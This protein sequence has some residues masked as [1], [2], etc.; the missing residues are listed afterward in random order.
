MIESI[1]SRNNPEKKSIISQQGDYTYKQLLQH[2][3]Q[4][5]LLFDTKGYSK[6][7]IYSENRIEWF[8]A[9]YAALQNKCIA[10]PIDFM[11][12]A[13]DVAYIIDDC[14]PD[15]IFLSDGMTESY[16]KVKQKS[17]HR[18]EEIIFENH[19]PVKDHEISGWTGPEDNDTTAVI[20]YTSGTTGSPKGVMLSYTNLLANMRA[21]VDARIFHAE[22]QVLVLLPLHHVFPLV[23]SMMVT[24]YSGG[25]TVVCPSMQ[26]SDLMKT[27]ADNAVTVFIGVPRLYE[28]IYRGLMAKINKS[29]LASTFLKLV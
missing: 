24:F 4:Y 13:E 21:V 20:I 29:F 28:L 26:S 11:A 25:T 12:S 17:R 22:S 23:G 14:Q 15:L 8:F 16:S 5:S 9:F 19:P 1:I 7:A 27:L 18:P 6:I 10:V 2:I 3:Q